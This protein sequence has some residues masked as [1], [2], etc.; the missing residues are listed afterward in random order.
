MTYGR[1]PSEVTSGERPEGEPRRL[2]VTTLVI[3]N[4][5]PGIGK[6]AV[7]ERLFGLLGNCALLD[8]ERWS[9]YKQLIF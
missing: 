1:S 3:I 7:G 4:G 2:Q 8:T 6:T 5:A 9:V